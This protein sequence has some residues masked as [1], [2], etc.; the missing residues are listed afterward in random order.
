[1]KAII[2]AAGRGSRLGSMTD[3]RPKCLVKLYGSPLLDWQINSL[4]KGGINEIVIVTG[5][6]K[7]FIESY[8]LKT[9]T[10]HEWSASNMVKSLL[11]AEK[12]IDSEVIVSYSDI[13]YEAE[14]V[15][16]L[17][18]QPGDIVITY[19][20]NWKE[21]WSKRFEDPL[22]DAESFSINDKGLLMDIGRLVRD[23]SEIRGQYMGLLKF[24]KRAMQWIDEI[25]IATP[26]IEYSLD[27]TKLLSLLLERGRQIMTLP[28]RGWWCEIDSE[29]DLQVAQSLIQK[30]KVPQIFEQHTIV[31]G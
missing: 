23:Y 13:V 4:R 20:P 15:K 29:A 26:G 14:I 28:A 22:S 30:N 12:E 27:M 10:N 5:Y 16:S 17:I 31:N 21:L 7:E 11:C 18:E 1:M 24:S 3:E 8:G 6:K 25:I 9:I 19:D 2:L